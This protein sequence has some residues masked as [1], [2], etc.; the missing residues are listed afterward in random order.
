[1]SVFSALW[2]L[3][4][5]AFTSATILPGSSELALIGFLQFFAEHWFIAWLVVSA[6]NTLG[7]ITSLVLGRIIPSK[8]QIPVK[9]QQLLQ[10]YGS[11]SMLLAWVPILGDA[12]PL[13]AGWLR[14]SFWSCCGYLLVG[15][16]L[17]YLILIVL[18]QLF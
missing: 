13:A 7:S 6:A 10:R 4:V 8:K 2:L 1:M 11:V 16:S 3:A 17:R 15:K 18:L 9:T 12:L 14:L 5:S